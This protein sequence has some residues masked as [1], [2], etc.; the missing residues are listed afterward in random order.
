MNSDILPVSNM[1]KC[2]FIS[3][4]PHLVYRKIIPHFLNYLM[5]ESLSYK[6]FYTSF[7]SKLL[8][9][10]SLNIHNEMKQ[11]IQEQNKRNFLYVLTSTYRIDD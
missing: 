11:N 8:T 5:V 4:D 1:I 2:C 7:Q 9:C 6:D 10:Y 3:V